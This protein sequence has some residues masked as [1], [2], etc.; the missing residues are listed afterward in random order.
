[1][2][3]KA[4]VPK[5]PLQSTRRYW[6]DFLD[7]QTIG[8][9]LIA[10]LKVQDGLVYISAPLY[11]YSTQQNISKSRGYIYQRQSHH[12]GK[13]FCSSIF[14]SLQCNPR[15]MTSRALEEVTPIAKPLHIEKVELVAPQP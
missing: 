11:A 6:K 13:D 5:E 3:G 4:N 9:V 14:T 15:H 1:M 2:N 10:K 7:Y 8:N 12:V